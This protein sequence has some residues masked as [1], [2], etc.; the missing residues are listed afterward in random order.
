MLQTKDKKRA[1]EE[2]EMRKM[3]M[4][5]ANFAAAGT[6]LRREF[7]RAFNIIV[8]KFIFAV[9][10]LCIVF[11]VSGC[12]MSTSNPHVQCVCWSPDQSY[13][14]QSLDPKGR[15]NI[16]GMDSGGM[17]PYQELHLRW[18]SVDETNKQKDI[19]LKS[20]WFSDKL[21]ETPSIYFSQDNT[22]IAI[23][24]NGKITVVDVATGKKSGLKQDQWHTEEWVSVCENIR[25]ME[26]DTQVQGKELPEGFATGVVS[27]DG[28]YTALIDFDGQVV[29]ENENLNKHKWISGEE[30]LKI[31]D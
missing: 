15:L 26:S 28:K 30:I 14:V 13:I 4:K 5:K 19:R 25:E 11:V 6:S 12:G 21:I 2:E 24:I 3:A 17:C 23:G 10:T 9:A 22:K 16:W 31:K 29:I 1:I 8:G 18:C 7:L 27:P 20:V